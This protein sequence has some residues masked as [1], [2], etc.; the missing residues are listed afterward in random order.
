ML[1]TLNLSVPTY[2]CSNTYTQECKHM[3]ACVH[4]HTHLLIFFTVLHICFLNT[5]CKWS[6]TVFILFISHSLHWMLI[7]SLVCSTHHCFSPFPPASIS[8]YEYIAFCCSVYLLGS[9]YNLTI[10]NFVLNTC[11]FFVSMF[12]S[13][14][15]TL[16]LAFASSW[17]IN[18]VKPVVYHYIGKMFISY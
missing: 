16:L 2:I 1:L 9:L 4:T 11:K 17:K 14:P 5:L 3:H 13:F 10:V 8:M 12:S 6:D 7:G 15:K 18:P